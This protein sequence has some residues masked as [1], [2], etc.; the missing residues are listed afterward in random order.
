MAKATINDD[1][2]TEQLRAENEKL[3]KKNQDLQDKVLATT[4]NDAQLRF[5]YTTSKDL[6]DEFRGED[7]YLAYMHDQ[8]RVARR[9]A[10]QRQLAAE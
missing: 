4:E 1:V 6:Q 8:A 3:A 10:F 2:R 7:R 9:P 5:R